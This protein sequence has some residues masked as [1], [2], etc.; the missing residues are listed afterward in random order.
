MANAAKNLRQSANKSN[1]SGDESA[2]GFITQ[3]RQ[4]TD[5]FLGLCGFAGCGIK[6][7]VSVIKDVAESWGYKFVHIR[8]SD[9]M[10]S[11]LYFEKDVIDANLNKSVDRHLSMQELGNGLRRHYGKNELLAEAA[12]AAINAEKNKPSNY[13]TKNR[14]VYLID[15]LKRSEEIELFRVIYQHN[16]YLMGI[17]RD[18]EHRIRNLREDGVSRE[19]IPN[20]MNVDDKSDDDFGQRTS[21]AILDS[22][23]FIKN[24]QS[25]KNDLEKKIY[26]FFGLIHGQNGLTPTFHEKGMYAAFSASLQSACL[27]RQVGAALFDDEGNLLAVG[28][29]DVPKAGGGLY[30]SD[31]G[32]H[33]HRCVHKSG[34][35]YNVSNKLKIKQKINDILSSEIK[36]TLGSDPAL[37]LLVKRIEVATDDISEKIYKG[38][39]IAS[40][41]EYSRSIHAEM[42]VITTMARKSNGGTKGKILYTTTYPCH[43]CARHIVSSGIK[44]VVYIEPFEKSLALDLHD[45]AITTGE[46]QSKVTFTD[47]EGISPRRYN[48]FF[49]PTGERKDEKT[50]VAEKFN[51]QYNNHIDVQYLDSHR[52][53]EDLVAKRFLSEVAKQMPLPE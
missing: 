32:D 5:I 19:D 23:I 7:V 1:H 14:T 27:S 50:G 25:Q 26:R 15:Q 30:G 9:L 22:D 3:K 42:D 33:D 38:S 12:I 34:K 16:F 18:Q 53:Y 24:N 6:T 48:K 10:Q 40:I 29:N 52:N 11:N 45:D 51:T 20:I 28:K 46:N 47:F 41:M 21:K 44:K 31:D 8:I 37:E 17:V 43:N 36:K 13:E 4:S 35:C 2:M 39:K 49:M